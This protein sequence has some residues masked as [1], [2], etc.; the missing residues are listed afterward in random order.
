MA[1][2]RSSGNISGATGSTYTV[3]EADEGQKISVV[4]SFTDD[5][6]DGTSDHQRGLHH[7]GNRGIDI[8]ADSVTG[9]DLRSP[10][11]SRRA[12]P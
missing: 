3:S 5:T 2:Q 1:E 12:P 7:H 9:V 4:A 6:E 8:A 10:A 11:S